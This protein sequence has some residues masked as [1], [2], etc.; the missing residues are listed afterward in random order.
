MNIGGRLIGKDQPVYVI[1]EISSNHKQSYET[2]EKLV[3]AA[4]QAGADAVKMQTFTADTITIDSDKPWFMVDGDANPDTWKSRTFYNLY[5][6]ASAPWEWHIPLQKLSLGLGLDFFSTPFDTTAVKYLEDIN[7][8]CYKI[9]AY[10]STD[11]LLLRSIAKTGKP[12]IMS[13][14]FASREEIEYSLQVLKDSGAR[15]IAL[16]HCTASY[17]EKPDLDAT[18]L[19]TM[20]DMRERYGVVVG[21][22]DNMGGI[23]IPGLAAAIGAAIIEKHLIY[24]HNPEV[25][26]DRF[27]IDPKEFR[28]MVNLIRNQERAMGT[29]VYGPRTKAEEHN[30]RFRRSLFVSKD[31]KAG[32]I[33][34]MENV[35]S[36]RPADGLETKYVD[37][38]IGSTA[39]RDIEY[40]TPLTWEMIIKKN[41]CCDPY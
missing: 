10:E 11:V 26:D 30:R 32:D 35:R 8:P 36:I 21:L 14:G 17:D 18:D 27:S 9:A 40:G 38:V 23:M 16:L 28:E 5:E 13:V 39:A 15:E 20:L 6:A 19:K 29:V 7:V 22:S 24:E 1:A 12:V 31:I 37:E 34:T 3:Y 41:E 25:F 4:K 33:F 2:A